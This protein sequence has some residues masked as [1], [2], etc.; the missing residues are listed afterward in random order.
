MNECR[1]LWYDRAFYRQEF[2]QKGEMHRILS[3]YDC[4]LCVSVKS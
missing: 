3:Y 4:I 1:H 2:I